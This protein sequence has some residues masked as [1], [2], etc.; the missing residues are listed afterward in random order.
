MPYDEIYDEL[1]YDSDDLKN[2]N[3]KNDRN[4]KNDIDDRDALNIHLALEQIVTVSDIPT[5]LTPDPQAKYVGKFLYKNEYNELTLGMCAERR[6]GDIEYAPGDSVAVSYILLRSLYSF[7]AQIISIREAVEEDRFYTEDMLNELTSIYGYNNFIFEVIPLTAPEKQQRREFFRMPLTIDIYY[8]PIS[9]L[10]MDTL[11]SADLKFELEEAREIKRDADEGFL[12]ADEGYL[13]LSTMDVSAGGF[14]CRHHEK[15]DVNTYLDCKL[16]IENE[17]LPV[18]A[19]I[20]GT[21]TDER[22]P[23]LYNLRASFY[24]ISDPVRDRLVKYIF[25]QQRQLQA[26]FLKRRF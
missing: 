21:K 6:K 15:L 4:D 11:K 26:K 24:K 5:R 3:D 14:K 8:K 17:A 9:E 19:R 13:K 25:Y 7:N 20:V 18:I 1:D 16:I 10:K 2:Q 23:R 22:N 12:E